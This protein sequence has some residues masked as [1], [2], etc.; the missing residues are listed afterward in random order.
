[1]YDY[2]AMTLSSP[3]YSDTVSTGR[4]VELS[5]VAI[6]GPLRE[7]WR[8]TACL[9]ALAGSDPLSKMQTSHKLSSLATKDWT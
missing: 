5:C 4:P 8:L 7:L 3:I 1:M 2:I 9:I 6:N